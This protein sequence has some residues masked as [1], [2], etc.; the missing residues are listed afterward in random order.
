MTVDTLVE[1]SYNTFLTDKEELPR[2]SILTNYNNIMRIMTKN[3]IRGKNPAFKNLDSEEQDFNHYRQDSKDTQKMSNILK[4]MNNPGIS[5]G[6]KIKRMGR[7]LPVSPA[8][9]QQ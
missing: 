8:R 2:L 1:P 3:Y 4:S 7:Y 5:P 6:K 9:R